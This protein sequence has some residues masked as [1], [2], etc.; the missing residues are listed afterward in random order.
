MSATVVRDGVT[1]WSGGSGLSDVAAGT[2]ATPATRFR[3][4]S[5]AKLFTAAALLRLVERGALGLD[6]P[7]GQYVTSIPAHVAPV[8]LRQ[9]AG[10]TA[11]IR[12]YRGAEFFVRAEYASMRAA[13]DIF[14]A[15]SL[16][17]PPGS[18]YAY[19][20]YGYNLIGAVMEAV[21]S[22]AFPVTMR[23]LVL[24]P[25]GMSGTTPDSAGRSIAD[26]S[27][28]YQ[29]SSGTAAPAPFDNLSS[30]WP[31]GG[32]L[33]TTRDMAR[34]AAALVRGELLR[35]ASFDVMV[36]PQSTTAG[37]P[38]QVGIGWRI[39]RDSAGRRYLHH[40][41]SSNGGSAFLLAY[42]EERLVIAVAANAFGTWG[43]PEAQRL[44]AL[45]PG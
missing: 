37:A 43:L 19:S 24:D 42:P 34:F 26:R 22:E 28:L 4:G 29:V 33:S 18:R 36:T 14:I 44:A 20:S 23:R 3:V 1:L 8:T 39:G 15:D 10:H 38:S 35:P 12:H 32:Y 27:Q 16:L 9:L 31:S 2:P 5:V 45:F 6:R 7:I 13:T 21:T 17:F 30:R 40:G 41:G 11:G 25:L